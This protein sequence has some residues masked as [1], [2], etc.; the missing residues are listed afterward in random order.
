MEWRELRLG[1]VLEVKHGFAFRGEHFGQGGET[2]LVTP[3]NFY[4]GGGFRDRGPEQKSYDGPIPSTYVLEP[5]AVIIAMTEQSRGLLG[6]SAVVPNDGK[7]WLH[8]Q[9]IGLVVTDRRQADPRFIYY[10]FNDPGVRNQISASA[11]G[12]KVRHTAPERIAAVQVRLPPLEAQRR[13]ASVLSAL[14]ELVEINERRIVILEGLARALYGEWFVHFRFPGCENVVLM[15]SELGPLPD[16]WTVGRLEDLAEVVTE[17]VNPSDLEPSDLY[18]GLEHLPRRRT[19]LQEWGSA[20]MVTS[21]KLKFS[22]G[23]TLFGKIRPYFHKVAWAPFPGTGS[24]DIVVLR[25]RPDEG[26]AALVNTVTSS[27]RFVAQAVATSNGTKMPRANP[28]ALL[29]FRLALP[30]EELR[31]GFE[32]IVRGWLEWAAELV[33]LNRHLAA[34][35]D[36]LLPRLVTGRLDISEVDLG[37]LTPPAPE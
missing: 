15:D 7:T 35:R 6:S 22:P 21:R 23:D 8:N 10:L 3:G 1:D 14:D 25:A 13:V 26:L 12:T 16:G 17:G 5:G 9:R 18:V 27:D 29:A 11:T 20:D 28:Q 4:E 19:T 34:T 33:R 2:R 36:L 24:S 37:V 31:R 32:R 30:P